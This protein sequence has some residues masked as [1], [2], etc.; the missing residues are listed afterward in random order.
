M[1][2]QQFAPVTMCLTKATLATGT[3]STLSTTGTT[4]FAIRSKF[5][6][7]TALTNVATPTTDWATGVAFLPILASQGSVFLVGFDHSGNLKVIQGT[8]VPLDGI[9][10]SNLFAPNGPQFGGTAPAGSVSSTT[11]D[12]CPIGYIVIAN[13][14]TGASWTFGTG[15]WAAT[16]ITATVVDVCGWPDRPQV[17]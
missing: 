4:T 16:G 13:G 6:T 15:T 11:G 12:F 9:V 1:D 2:N 5:Y 3:T 17:A 7:K 10:S 14:T 8:V